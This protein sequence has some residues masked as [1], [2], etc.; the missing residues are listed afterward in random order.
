MMWF[1]I[2]LGWIIIDVVWVIVLI[3]NQRFLNEWEADIKRRHKYMGI[4]DD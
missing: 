3:K 2:A 1:F 4:V